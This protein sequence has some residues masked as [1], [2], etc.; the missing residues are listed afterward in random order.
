MAVKLGTHVS[1]TIASDLVT[2]HVC[3]QQI[4]SGNNII[5]DALIPNCLIVMS[6]TVT[7]GT[8]VIPITPDATIFRVCNQQITSGNKGVLVIH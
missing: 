6:M 8:R 5:I 3:K 4:T 2:L 1:P 7:L